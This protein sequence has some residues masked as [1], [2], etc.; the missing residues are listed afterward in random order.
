ML[1][2]VLNVPSKFHVFIHRWHILKMAVSG[3]SD[4]MIKLF[5]AEIKWAVLELRMLHPGCECCPPKGRQCGQNIRN[6]K[7]GAASLPRYCFPVFCPLCT[8]SPVPCHPALE[9]ASYELKP[10]QMV[11]QDKP[12]FLLLWVSDI[13]FHNGN[14]IKILSYDKKQKGKRG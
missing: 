1:W 7:G 4:T 3:V 13:L 10:L 6:R 5:D 12:F 11:I 8:I 9:L 2:L 14:A